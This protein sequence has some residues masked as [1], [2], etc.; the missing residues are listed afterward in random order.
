MRRFDYILCVIEPDETSRPALGRAV[1]LAES[2]QAGLTVVRV[3][4][5]GF[6]TPV[7]AAG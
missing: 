6:A 4:S 1:A 7:T 5:L 2:N 3:M